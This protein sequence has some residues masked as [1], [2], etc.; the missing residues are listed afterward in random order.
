M[1]ISN[2]KNREKNILGY[3]NAK[4]TT[5]KI[6]EQALALLKEEVCGGKEQ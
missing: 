3:K 4:N 1:E 2:L 6:S 5:K